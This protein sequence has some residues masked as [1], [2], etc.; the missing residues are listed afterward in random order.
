VGG[1]A[2]WQLADIRPYVG[3]SP[4]WTSVANSLCSEVDGAIETH[5]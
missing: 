1:G 2:R 4:V 3:R 5:A